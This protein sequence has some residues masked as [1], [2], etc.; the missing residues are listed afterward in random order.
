[1]F[2]LTPATEKLLTVAMA[3][4]N[5]IGCFK[6]RLRPSV[7]TL[8]MHPFW[9]DVRVIEQLTFFFPSAT[10]QQTPV[11]SNLLPNKLQPSALLRPVI[12]LSLT[13]RVSPLARAEGQKQE[14]THTHTS[15]HCNTGVG[16]EGV[17][18]QV[19][20]QML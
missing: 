2:Y 7:V 16:L 20:L 1:M 10:K 6:T 8:N 5:A 9:T 19:I 17:L 12:P 11:L 14:Y 4:R 15:Q 13:C 3:Q 18:P